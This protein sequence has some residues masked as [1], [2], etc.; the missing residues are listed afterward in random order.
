[1]VD[2]CQ[3]VHDASHEE[4]QA[5]K[6]A[7][8]VDRMSTYMRFA[9]ENLK[10]AV[11]L[12]DINLSLSTYL[13]DLLHGFEVTL[14]NKMD[15]ALVDKYSTTYWFDDP[16]FRGLIGPKTGQRIDIAKKRASIHGNQI[17]PGNVIAE[18]T[19]GF[20]TTLYSK[21]LYPNLWKNC[22]E[23]IW[24]DNTGL[25]RLR[26]DLEAIRKL[27]N[28]VA[29]HEPVFLNAHLKTHKIILHRTK[30]LSAATKCMFQSRLNGQIIK[31]KTARNIILQ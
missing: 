16:K 24:P 30:Q 5:L 31:L 29:H 3:Y 13:F 11:I 10:N 7:F 17:K 14:R 22:L 15:R 21:R 6:D 8:S 27:R 2:T 9:N 19:L 23:K 20:W 4:L 18:Q 25:D 1:M 28:R 26:I 12:Y